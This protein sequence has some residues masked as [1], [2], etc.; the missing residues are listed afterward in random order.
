M[1]QEKN[2][3]FQPLD[4]SYE[5]EGRKPKIIIWS[6]LRDGN[7]AVIED[8]R[9][10]PYFYA[11]PVQDDNY[12]EKIKREI[13]RECSRK[14][15][16]CM[17]QVNTKKYF[18]RNIKVLR[19][20]VEIPEQVRQI[21]D[22]IKEIPG[23]EDV[24][25]ADVRFSLR[26]MIDNDMKP[27]RWYSAKVKEL[28]K[29]N[30]RVHKV[31]EMIDGPRE[32]EAESAPPKLKMFAFDIEVYSPAGS[33]KPSQDPI[34]IIGTMNGGIK[35]FYTVEKYD[36]KVIEDF[37]MKIIEEDPDL[38]VGY[39]TNSFDWQYLMERSKVLKVNL[40]IGR[41]MNS[42]PSMS[43]M[44]HVSIQGRLNVDIF[45]FVEEMTGT[46]RKTLDE[47]AEYM[48][49]M[50]KSE[51]TLLEWY[52]IPKLWDSG[53]AGIEKVLAYNKDD[54]V[55]TYRLAEKFIPFGIQLSGL[56][57]IPLDQIMAASVGFRLEYYLMRK[58]FKYGELVPNREERGR[59]TYKGAIVLS[60]KPG[61][62]ENVAVLDFASM[63][64]NIM[65]KY[66]VGPDTLVK[67]EN[68]SPEE[69]YIAPDVGHKFRKEPSGFFKSVLNELLQA[70]KKMREE[71][72]KYKPDS[73][74]YSILD[75]R[76]KAV[77]VLANA[78]Y[79]YMGWQA[80][81]WYC[82]ECAEAITAWG[83]ANIT[84]AI[85][86]AKML[87]LS[88]IYGDTDSLFVEN[89]PESVEKLIGWI[90]DELG[91]E[92]K[93][94]KIYKRLFFTEAKK[95]Y[96]GLTQEG[97]IDIVGFEAIRGDWSEIA[98]DIQVE[99]AR[100]VLE[101]MST[102]KAVEH[103]KNVIEMLRRKEIPMDKLV[104]WKTITKR[105]EEYE[106]DAPHVATAKMYE[107]YGLKISPGDKVGYVVIKGGGKISEKVKPYF[108]ASLEEIDVDYYAEHQI[109][110]AALR[111][112]EYFGVKEIELKGQSK[113]GQKS[114]MDFFGKSK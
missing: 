26:Y 113:G 63:Y 62:H 81:R 4:V 28:E 108:A 73:P 8:R 101:E 70:R 109:I 76:Q 93:V 80:A 43:V 90:N 17:V 72:K 78:T 96:V 31:F 52:D 7:T 53:K 47:I 30:Y 102:K 1:S 38:I 75:E 32:L 50:K 18:G 6:K 68:C 112:L 41:K 44:G 35:Q 34:I 42:P 46:K 87:G 104:I 60:P 16:A 74:E 29:G 84:S 13:E 83:R 111:I 107:S 64:P 37:A 94:D 14:K 79:G 33:P 39:N 49:V 5:V 67:D 92:I 19:I 82:R 21:R 61:V 105:I 54:V 11:I 59:E 65:I 58:A 95:R 27:F 103:V 12:I 91:L 66:N 3:E 106:V 99:V 77:K 55:S 48:G 86:K 15:I 85:D 36:K 10:L 69:C 98:K 9:F 51:R 97:A 100:L 40:D 89:K 88:V 45:N 23:V 114:L 24:L 71:M 22:A 56:T 2:I 57:G 20:V 110:P 25:E